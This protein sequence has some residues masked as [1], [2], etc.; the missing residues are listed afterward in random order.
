M[1]KAA[2][3][4]LCDVSS[5]RC[6]VTKAASWRHY[7]HRHPEL[8]YEEHQTSDFVASQ[9]GSFG[10]EVHRRLADTG[11]VGVLKRGTSKRAIGIRADMD[12][13]PLEE[14]S[15]TAHSSCTTGIMHAC[16]HDGHTTMLLAAAKACAELDDMDGTVHFIFQ[17]AEEGAGGGERMVQEGLFKRFPCD[18]VFGLHNWPALPLGTCLALDGPIMGAVG[19]FE[20]AITGKGC[21]GAFPHEGQDVLLAASHVHIALQSIISRSLDAR[22]AAV[23]SVT[24]IEAGNSWN[25]MPTRCV[26]RGTARWLDEDTGK[27]IEA[28]VREIAAA[29]AATFA[30]QARVSYERA[31][32]ATINDPAAAAM[33]REVARSIGV[34][35]VDASPT[36]G[37]EDFAFML[38]ACSGAYVLLGSGRSGN[39][40]GLHSPYYDFND[41]LLPVGIQLWVALVRHC[42]G[43]SSDD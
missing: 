36:L 22:K 9:L 10:L 5:P 23:V 19:K 30:C 18:F 43:K 35:I 20:I 4:E 15:G 24:Q 2:E 25:V 6:L 29:A 13:L 34:R 21:H 17:P 41:D 8:A 38:Q 12:A 37:A 27:L 31:T 16:G 1:D 3:D 33:I 40:P 26:L 11:V 14:R 7:L 28:R 32:P 39:E 42:L